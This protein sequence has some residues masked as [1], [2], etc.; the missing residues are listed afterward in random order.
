M[1]TRRWTL[2]Q[3][4]EGL[5]GTMHHPELDE[6]PNPVE[7]AHSQ[8][9][10]NH[11]TPTT[12]TP[13]RALFMALCSGKRGNPTSGAAVGREEGQPELHFPG[14]PHRWRALFEA[15][16]KCLHPDFNTGST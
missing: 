1:R 7:S 14:H 2:V 9:G 16:R 6:L 5:S 10:Q 12:A 11:R 13:P 8:G 4:Q 15:H 3:R